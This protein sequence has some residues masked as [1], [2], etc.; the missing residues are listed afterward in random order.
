MANDMNTLIVVAG[1]GTFSFPVADQTARDAAEAAQN[2]ANSANST[3]QSASQAA[4]TAQQTAE[5]AQAVAQAAKQ[6]AE[7]IIV[8]TALPNPFKLIFTGGATGEYDG[9]NAVTI[10]IP[11][12]GEG[13]GSGPVQYVESLDESNLAN[14]RDLTTGTYVLYGYFVPH[15]G[16]SDTMV[17]DNTLVSVAHLTAGS[18]VLV[19]NP[20]NCKVNFIE[21]LVDE[22]A[23]SGFTYSVQ[24][25][26]MRDLPALIEAV[27]SRDSLTTE[28]KST[29]VAAINEV[30]GIA[31]GKLDAD[32]L[33]EAV[34]DA[35]AQAKASG[36]FK[37]DPG[38]NAERFV[39]TVTEDDESGYVA[40]K[41]FAEIATA[42]MDGKDIW[43]NCGGLLCQLTAY[44]WDAFY[45]TIIVGGAQQ[46]ILIDTSSVMITLTEYVTAEGIPEKL[47][48]PNALTFT[49]AVS[50]T[51]DGSSAQT[52]NIPTIAGEPG[53]NGYTPVKGTDYWT[54][55][56]KAEM[57]NDVLTALPVWIG[58]AY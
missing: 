8:P 33:Q 27:G 25:I 47:P 41:I 57:V 19:F 36:E 51:Y 39:V 11:T 20:L 22:S 21:I 43:C 49:G 29:I 31:S 58:G 48:N 1:N 2:T 52:I 32:K 37:G 46:D 17:C 30:A 24:I 42:Y 10:N 9:S 34:N 28:D 5:T 3:A 54:D 45:F 14:L 6:A 23:D 38:E 18:H 56:D 26:D 50:G 12:G 15:A 44:T 4:G 7:A 16:S 35:L 13:G 53:A 40:D 55:A